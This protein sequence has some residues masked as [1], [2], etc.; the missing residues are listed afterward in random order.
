MARANS[1]AMLVIV[2]LKPRLFAPFTSGPEQALS[3]S[4]VARSHD[5]CLSEIK[6]FEALPCE[7]PHGLLVYC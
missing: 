2:S 1:F 5:N 3:L 7:V 6:K 4:L